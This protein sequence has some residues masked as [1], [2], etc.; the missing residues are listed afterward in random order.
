MKTVLVLSFTDL[1]NDPRVNRQLRFL[2]GRYRVIAAGLGDP[3]LDGVEYVALDAPPN[4]KLRNLWAAFS[5]ACRR[6]HA[7]YW[8]KSL[9]RQA[10][11]KLANVRAD[12][13]IAND[14]V[15]LPLARQLAR[16]AR[17]LLDAHEYAPRETEDRLLWRLFFD[18]L[19]TAL[20]REHIPHV[21]AMTTVCPGIA[22]AYEELTGVRATVITNAPDYEALSP[23]PCD[24]ARP[25]QLVHHGIPYP[26]RK[27]ENMITMMDHLD[28]R[29]EL[30][31]LLTGGYAAYRRK[32]ETMARGRPVRFLP[33]VPMR[34]LP[35][36]LNQF[37]IGVF[38]LEPVNFS[39][40]LALPNKLFE[41]IQARLAVAI[42]P[43]PEMARVV[44]EA[45]CGVIAGDFAPASLA[46]CLNRLGAEQI[47]AM[48]AASHACAARLSAQANEPIFLG[49]IDQL[50]NRSVR[51]AA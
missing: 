17:V 11:Y 51:I 28:D 25:I 41:F 16:G 15:T 3:R 49:L 8:Q 2:A 23:R 43:S 24:P 9:I 42:G 33:P 7:Y 46:G 47:N 5:L 35:T 39:Y 12:V 19:Q 22:D 50:A 26:S 44:R 38:L 27:L 1:A 37:D 30:N 29:F 4:G 14:I 10:L 18:P 45:S 20:C 40:R 21:D 32:L 31:F 34:S 36:F 6:Y 48:K 13:I